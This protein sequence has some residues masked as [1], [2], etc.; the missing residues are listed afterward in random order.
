M[1]ELDEI[2][3]VRCRV[4]NSSRIEDFCTARDRVLAGARES[5]HIKRCF[6]CG[7]GWTQPVPA[8][9]A[10]PAYYPTSYLG[11]T[12][13]MLDDFVSGK[14]AGSRFWRGEEEKVRLVQSF[15][16]GGDI[17]DVGCGNA[18]FLLALDPRCWRRSGID[19]ARDT[20]DLVASR[21]SSLRLISGSIET[22]KLAPGSFDALTFWH[23]LEHL[24][25]PVQALEKAAILLRPNGWIFV[26]LPNLDSFQAQLFR[27]YWYCFD[28]V[29]R[30]LH[31]FSKRSLDLLL[32]RAG[33]KI[34]RHL[35]F[36][37]RVNFHSLKHS[38]LHW[39]ADNFSSHVPYYVLKPFLFAFPLLEALTGKYGIMTTVAQKVAAEDAEK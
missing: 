36:S 10:L 23:V 9:E 22:A 32:Q 13:G 1:K 17:L 15:I 29:P 3:P 28:D 8:A 7:F 37:R 11:D 5:W 34:R 25:D 27:R 35:F 18:R 31:H 2:R 30:H 33:L 14:L 20:L 24:P 4:C 16:E 19:F 38:L 12:A 6:S 21:V 26:S 39:S